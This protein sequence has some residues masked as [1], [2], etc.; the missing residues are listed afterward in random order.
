MYFL[1]ISVFVFLFLRLQ[2]NGTFQSTSYGINMQ[3]YFFKYKE[4]FL[5]QV[6]SREKRREENENVKT[7]TEPLFA[8]T[9]SCGQFECS[10]IE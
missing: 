1:L 4:P 8:I 2:R 6:L 7:I 5:K 9:K 3:A 10:L